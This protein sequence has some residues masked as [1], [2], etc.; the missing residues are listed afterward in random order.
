MPEDLPDSWPLAEAGAGGTVLATRPAATASPLVVPRLYFREDFPRPTGTAQ[1]VHAP[2]SLS[3]ERFSDVV[4]APRRV[5]LNKEPPGLMQAS[6]NGRTG[7]GHPAFEKRGTAFHPRSPADF[8]RVRRVD[9]PLYWADTGHPQIFGHLLLEVLPQMWAYA[10]VK[11]AKVATSV[12]LDRTALRLMEAMGVGADL[13]VPIDGCM[14]P[15][16][17]YVA[18]P[19][20][21]LHDYVH[22]EAREVFARLGTLGKRS[23]SSTS[24]RIYLSRSRASRRILTN[25]A[26]IEAI[27]AD[28]GFAIYHPQEHPIEDQIRVISQARLIA[29]PGGSAA[30]SSVFADRLEKLLLLCSP[31]WF[32]VID[33]L[34]HQEEGKLALLFGEVA[35]G[36]SE[37]KPWL[38]DWT[39]N[40]HQVRMTLRFYMGL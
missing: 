21:M 3:L 13:I 18:T 9:E 16:E 36:Q 5:L 19:P 4:I 14:E 26:E 11:G 6:F 34:L 2:P 23:D 31:D 38:R 17:V 27:F 8:R 39:V 33:M 35:M 20:V 30:L 10:Q 29:G 15:S 32:N 1:P 28:A 25:E 12:P 37:H 24:G 40:P 22:P 7:L